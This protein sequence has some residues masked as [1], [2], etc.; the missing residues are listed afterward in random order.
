[1]ICNPCLPLLPIIMKPLAPVSCSYF[2]T[3]TDFYLP[4][5]TVN[6]I[7][8]CIHLTCQEMLWAS[9]KLVIMKIT[10]ELITQNNWT[11]IIKRT[12]CWTAKN[13]KQKQ[14][15]Q[16]ATI[17]DHPWESTAT[18]GIHAPPV[19]VG[20]RLQQPSCKVS[21]S[22]SLP[23][24]WGQWWLVEGDVDWLVNGRLLVINDG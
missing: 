10:T 13:E 14:Q 4:L 9:L 5:T 21:Q 20:F 19:P 15:L 2:F 7:Q 8:I 17:Q 22:W 6:L 16:P 1:M 24:W 12:S 11:T 3:A 18:L 23:G